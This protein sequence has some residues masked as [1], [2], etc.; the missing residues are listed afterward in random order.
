MSRE[1]GEKLPLT[2]RVKRMFGRRFK[3][4]GYAAF[5]A[6]LVVAI[7]VVV[8]LI[9]SS[10]PVSLT[11]IDMTNQSLFT[12]GDQTKRVMATLDKDVTLYLLAAQGGEDA[13]IMRLL[14]RYAELSDHITVETVDPTQK[15]TF[16]DAYDLNISQLY[17]NSVLVE[18][19]ERT[20]LVGYD[21]IF[22]TNYS[23]DYNSYSY[24][25]TTDFEGEGV[26][27]NAIY[28]LTSDD[29]PMIYTLSGHGELELS[30]TILT[31]LERD[32]LQT[33][34]LSLLS[35][36]RVPEDAAAVI[37]DAPTDDI[38][39]DEA[40]MLIT[41]LQEGGSVLLMTDYI[42]PGEMEN[43]LR[44]AQSMGL[45]VGDGLIVEGDASMQLSRYPYYLL[46]DMTSHEITD[47]LIE[48]RYYALIPLAQPLLET[49]DSEASVTWLLSTS[50]TAYAKAAGLEMT[51][52]AREDGDT[53][54]PFYVAAVSELGDGK[55]FFM[56]SAGWL[57]DSVN[58]AVA[59][60]NSDLFLNAL[61]W[62]AGQVE[63]ISI[64]A[65]SLDSAGL[66]LT[67]AQNRL[68]TFVFIGLIPLA[69]I[70]TGVIIRV[71]RKRR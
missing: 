51:T 70:A 31:L 28:A 2:T 52:T 41:Y 56:P 24:T 11:Q 32:N 63:T 30:E 5:A 48:G 65:K 53:D 40:D 37:I 12:L 47:P 23:M 69:F 62:M 67:G 50:D 8:N 66:T 1:K 43:L 16:L 46:P 45:T 38:S 20:R 54:G 44:V 26:L 61:G 14:D 55:L 27:T 71:R 9:V 60:A 39:A 15:P 64:R 10:L 42:A 19:G 6:V 59:G 36:E 35:L 68:W 7:A 3:A 18:C 34:S 13:T 22:V 25:T 17:A 4:G 57:T 29:V 21:E 33:E 49:Q 58:M